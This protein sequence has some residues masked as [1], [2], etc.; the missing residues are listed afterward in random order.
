M[1]ARRGAIGP[2]CLACFFSVSNCACQPL[3]MSRRG[4]AIGFRCRSR[5]SACG[6]GEVAGRLWYPGGLL[7]Q[8]A[9]IE[10]AW[11]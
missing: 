11:R 2:A 5:S 3:T 9:A 7:E 1:C 8:G 4:A 10:P 6:G